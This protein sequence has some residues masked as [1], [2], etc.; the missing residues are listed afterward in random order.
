MLDMR[1]SLITVLII[2]SISIYGQTSTPALENDSTGNVLIDSINGKIYIDRVQEIDLNQKKLKEKVNRW[3]AKT[4]NNSNHV[5]R[6]NIE[7]NI[8]LKGVFEVGYTMIA[9]GQSTYITGKVDYTLDLLFKDGKYKIIIETSSLRFGLTDE[10]TPLYGYFVSFEEYRV[11]SVKRLGNLI[12]KISHE[13]FKKD[14]YEPHKKYGKEVV[15][16]IVTEF[17]MI[18]LSLL[19]FLIKE[20]DW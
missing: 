5:I 12:S 7:D 20:D 14:Y 10:S 11:E 3:V 8:L 17:E 1:W 4:Y 13:Q 15:S 18:D 2:S 6:I 9:Y 16:Q 19:S